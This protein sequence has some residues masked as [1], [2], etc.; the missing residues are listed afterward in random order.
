MVMK[1]VRPIT[2]WYSLS[3]A[4]LNR[5]VSWS[6]FCSCDRKPQTSLVCIKNSFF[7]LMVLEASDEALVVAL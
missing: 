5:Q 6:I 3:Y 7:W 4:K 2:E 1:Q